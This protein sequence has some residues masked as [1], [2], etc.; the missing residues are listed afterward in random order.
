M[1]FLELVVAV[2]WDTIV[3]DLAVLCFMVFANYTIR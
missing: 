2:P 1:T 3:R